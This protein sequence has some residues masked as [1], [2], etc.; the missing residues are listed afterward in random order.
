LPYKKL[1]LYIGQARQGAHP[2][3]RSRRIRGL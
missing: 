3:G 2:V 1:L